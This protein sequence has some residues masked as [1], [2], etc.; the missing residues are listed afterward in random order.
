[1][2][3]APRNWAPPYWVAYDKHR[4]PPGVT[5]DRVVKDTG[6]KDGEACYHRSITP[7]E[8]QSIEME[9]IHP[10]R[11]FAVHRHKR[12][13]FMNMGRRIGA[14]SGEETTY[15][16]VEHLTSGEVHGRP[17]TIRDL[18]RKGAQI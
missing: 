5:W 4:P 11:L 17:A 14:S 3:E 12:M 8:Q 13:Y 6:R 7:A 10:D 15:I 18:R 2:A 1:V 9:C 16:Y